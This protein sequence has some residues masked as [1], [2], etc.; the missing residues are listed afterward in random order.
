M[1]RASAES[2]RGS[3]R[4]SI[5]DL[6][7]NSSSLGHRNEATN[8]NPLNPA[9]GAQHLLHTLRSFGSDS[10][11][12][13]DLGSPP[14]DHR[15][16]LNPLHTHHASYE[17]G[18]S[19][20]SAGSSAEQLQS[21][22][23]SNLISAVE[24]DDNDMIAGANQLSLGERPSHGFEER[25]PNLEWLSRAESESRTPRYHHNPR[26][27][28][29]RQSRA[30]IAL[31]P[32][33]HD[34]QRWANTEYE[35]TDRLQ[36]L[37]TRLRDTDVSQYRTPTSHRQTSIPLSHTHSR[38]APDSLSSTIPVIPLLGPTLDLGRMG[39]PP[40]SP[41]GFHHDLACS[42]CFGQTIDTVL[43]PCGHAV[44]CRWC[45]EIL[46]QRHVIAQRAEGVRHRLKCPVC[47]NP[48][49]ELVSFCVLS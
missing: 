27:E 36:E 23:R 29:L 16:H 33:G 45:A 11:D 40:F 44:T 48:V 7:L 18:S 34:I 24:D 2:T 13:D 28:D 37:R 12:D 5:Q 41:L 31:G 49:H 22:S 35:R 43:L 38:S 32:A 19:L 20:L 25:V 3:R 30:R 6:R 15:I 47:R 21:L 46:V 14:V 8:I 1:C 39:P 17:S 42:I 26:S 10:S 4:A 9:H